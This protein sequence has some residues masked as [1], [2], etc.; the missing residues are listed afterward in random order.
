M[1]LIEPQHHCIGL[2]PNAKKHLMSHAAVIWVV[3]QR[4]HNDCFM[5]A[6]KSVLS[7]DSLL[8]E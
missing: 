1:Y 2:A 4:S 8:P 6:K 7:V 5:L 3:A